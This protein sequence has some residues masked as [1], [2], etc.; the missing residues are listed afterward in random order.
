MS[1]QSQ[2]C[3]RVAGM[4]IAALLV[5][6]TGSEAL[7]AEA[8]PS[9]Y[10]QALA[11]PG[12][13]DKDKERDARDKPAEVLAFAGFKRGMRIADIFGAGGYYSEILAA[14]VGPQGKVLLVN[15]PGYAR[16]AAKAMAERF[17]D[18]RLAAVERMEV[19]SEH[20]GL[21]KETLDGALFVMS[22]H[23][24]YWEDKDGFPRI[25]AAQFLEQVRA[26]MKPGAI[27]L[28]VDHAAVEGSG[29]APA[30]TLHR[31]D[32]KFAIADWKS[33]GFELVKSYDGLRNPADDRLKPVFDEA[34]RGK[35]DRFV[36]V[37][38]RL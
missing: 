16:F 20:L 12:R 19:P 28:I 34:I 23:D 15:N 17:K 4:I 30:Q 27:L 3:A 10:A 7:A 9:V 36:H 1:N 26:A 32:E 8:T 14:V 33:H 2:I 21:G 5:G 6:A 35:T 29:S 18:G 13:S 31:I 37:Y 38:R 11:T 25:D 24:L 22:Y